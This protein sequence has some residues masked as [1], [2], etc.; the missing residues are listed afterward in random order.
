MTSAPI[1]NHPI[2][3]WAV[4]ST[5]LVFTSGRVANTQLS[6]ENVFKPAGS[7][8]RPRHYSAAELAI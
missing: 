2:P 7:Y 1:V 8:A 4:L 3:H 5:S 6:S